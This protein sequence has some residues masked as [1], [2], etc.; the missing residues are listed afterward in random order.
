MKGGA[1]WAREAACAGGGARRCSCAAVV[2]PHSPMVRISSPSLTSYLQVFL[3]APGEERRGNVTGAVGRRAMVSRARLPP[4]RK[5][6]RRSHSLQQPPRQLLRRMLG[7]AAA[8]IDACRGESEAGGW[9]ADHRVSGSGA[10]RRAG[11][12]AAMSPQRHSPSAAA[13]RQ[14]TARVTASSFIAARGGL[15]SAGGSAG[16]TQ[17]GRYGSRRRL[18]GLLNQRQRGCQAADSWRS[19][20]AAAVVTAS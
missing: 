8:C 11:G 13:S 6:R 12:C 10:R 5:L 18:D 14:N 7:S 17:N 19:A 20:A 3:A 9:R 2:C 16:R 15:A 1:A 4:P